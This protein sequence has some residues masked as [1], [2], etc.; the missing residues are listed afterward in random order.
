MEDLIHFSLYKKQQMKTKITLILILLFS[1]TGYG[2]V[3]EFL[4]QPIFLNNPIVP[5]AKLLIDLRP[6]QSEITRPLIIA[7]GFDPGSITSPE[8]EYG[9]GD[10][11]DFTTSLF[12]DAGN[13]LRNL[14]DPTNPNQEYDI[15][16]VNWTNGTD[17][18]KE[19]AKV[20]K[21]VIDWVNTNKQGDE[22]NVLL[23][24][25]MGG[26]IGRYTLAKMEKDGQHHDVRLFIAHDSP[27]VSEKSKLLKIPSKI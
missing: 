20:L 26:L 5:R 22:P 3:P 25:S 11:F 2:Q 19:N 17:D 18:I 27:K 6:N 14:I 12:Q 4:E 16:Y 23:G 9:D 21:A 15:I 8:K 24:Q 7:E 10:I 13:N 1:I